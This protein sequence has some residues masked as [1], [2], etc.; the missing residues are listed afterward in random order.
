M[1]RSLLIMACLLLLGS[2]SIAGAMGN[3]P[4]AK[5]EP[6]YKL[7]ILK[8]EIVP[9]PTPASTTTTLKPGSKAGSH[10]R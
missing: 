2:G 9:A 1:K 5:A 8:M 3:K 4:P 10:G 6:K 7:E